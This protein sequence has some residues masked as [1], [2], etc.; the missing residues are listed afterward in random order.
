[1]THKN[2]QHYRPINRLMPPL[3]HC[4]YKWQ[5]GR[6]K[7][8]IFEISPL[9]YASKYAK[10]GQICILAHIWVRQI[11]SSGVSLKRSCKMLF[12]RVGLRSIGPSSQKL[13][14][15]QILDDCAS[16]K[17]RWLTH[18]LTTWNQEM[19][20]HL[21]IANVDIALNLIH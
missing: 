9:K 17:K 11:W 5:R 12:R 4:N 15:Y 8:T 6:P 7:K 21:K 14:P 20:A 2:F 3:L 1:M 10:I 16:C 13:W 18:S 19:L